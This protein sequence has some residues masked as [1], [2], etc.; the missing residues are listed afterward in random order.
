M[1]NHTEIEEK[2]KNVT[3]IDG[4]T[5]RWIFEGM[6]RKLDNP[7]ENATL[8]LIFVNTTKEINM[9]LGREFPKRKLKDNEVILT[10]SILRSL[11]IDT[12]SNPTLE[13]Y[14]NLMSFLDAFYNET[15]LQVPH[16]NYDNFQAKSALKGIL[17]SLQNFINDRVLV[18]NLRLL[19][20]QLVPDNMMLADFLNMCAE[21][22]FNPLILKH[23][24]KV[25]ASVEEPDGKWPMALGKVMLIDDSYL[26]PFIIRAFSDNMRNLLS[27]NN[28]IVR[29][30]VEIVLGHLEEVEKVPIEQYVLITQLSLKD[31]KQ[32]YTRSTEE[33][34][35]LIRD[36]IKQLAMDCFG[37]DYS[38]KYEA[39][40]LDSV[41]Q[42]G[43]AMILLD[44]IFMIVTF[45]L[46]VLS[47]LLIYSLMMSVYY[48]F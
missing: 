25:V 30:C 32:I 40:L 47:I 10:R 3:F 21:Q 4:A 39:V 6:A 2:L 24:F 26:L 9:G 45:F 29:I 1:L 11:D 22:E 42:I 20:D 23:N 48:Y 16:I 27:H 38:A 44:S 19:I 33:R 18:E 17:G 28:I 15:K 36:H 5:P 34:G 31:R 7:K 14:I 8:T 12:S 35:M 46:S 37:L 13:L 43:M 41:D